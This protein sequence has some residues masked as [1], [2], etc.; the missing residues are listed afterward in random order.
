MA[1]AFRR[2][3]LLAAALNL[4][5]PLVPERL[6]VRRVWGA[7]LHAIESP[8]ARRP[9]RPMEVGETRTVS[10]VTEH[11]L[12]VARVWIHT[13][14]NTTAEVEITLSRTTEGEGVVVA[15]EHLRPAID[16]VWYE[17]RSALAPPGSY[18]IRVTVLAGTAAP[19]PAEGLAGDSIAWIA[20]T[21]ELVDLQVRTG[22]SGLA[23][24]A[25]TGAHVGIELPWRREGYSVTAADG[26]AFDT[27]IS[28][29]GRYV[30]AEEFKRMSAWPF[31]ID[32]I[33]VSFLS[34]DSGFTLSAPDGL[35]LTG[36][37]SNDTMTIV[38][39]TPTDGLE[40][41]TTASRAELTATLPRFEASDPAFAQR[42][43]RFFWERA[44]SWPFRDYTASA[45]GWRHWMTRVLS[46]T[47]TDGATGQAGDLAETPQDVQGWLWTRTDCPGWPF[48]DPNRY[49]TRHPS[50]SLSF[51]AGVVTHYSWT[52]DRDFLDAQLPRV[53]KALEHIISTYGVR[54]HGL[55][56]NTIADQDGQAGSL[57]SHYWDIVPGG[58][59]DAYAN[60]M[61]Y[62]AV[63]QSAR[64]ERHLGEDGRA[65]DLDAL[66]GTVKATFETEFWNDADGRFVQNID[67]TGAVHDYGASYLNLEALAVGLGTDEQARRIIDWLDHGTT[68]LTDRVLL[69]PP[70]GDSVPLGPGRALIQDFEAASQFRTVA[71]VITA[72]D[73]LVGFTLALED[74][75]GAQL[76][77]RHFDRWWDR[78]WAH[79]DAGTQPP[80]SYRL[81]VTADSRGLGWQQSRGSAANGSPVLSMAAVSDHHPGAPDIYSAWRFA[82]RA[83][84]RRNDFWYTFG[85]SGVETSY[86]DQV[87]DGGT[88]LYISGFDIEARARISA[89]L[90]FR[91]LTE[92]LD[93][94]DQPDRLC[95]GA[96]LYHGEIPQ[97]MLPGQVGVDNPFPESGL[98]PFAALPAFLGAVPTPEGLILRPHLP[99]ALGW[100]GVTN[101]H[102]RGERLRI[103]ANRESVTVATANT[104]LVC[105]VQGG[106][107]IL[108]QTTGE[109]HHMLHPFPTTK[110]FR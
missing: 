49:D 85:W 28:S 67:A 93:R 4:G 37:M 6:P 62:E 32:D 31:A 77:R 34:G 2:E 99:E 94:V 55:L 83:S 80:G 98:V 48:P 25:P 73:P 11:A 26:V 50:A 47:G 95:G 21:I 105:S 44:L 79:L 68:E 20:E 76:E 13:F 15:R 7:Q 107:A 56:V 42:L 18:E 58:H 12:S 75:E 60:A 106:Q 104:E 70:S 92:I 78:G 19:A 43:T 41:A 36:R 5:V 54:E 10:L 64:L 100:F 17:L 1:T 45:V 38:V 87:Q 8:P 108:L 109:G 63:I 71:V 82:P 65:A 53:R 16:Q 103:V 57:G 97:A 59:K 90:A 66:A 24:I 51:V 23:L 110:G 40:L 46:W 88:S 74:P 3:E 14:G 52:G 102:W 84:T 81:R 86:A 39:T 30:P 33:A 27:V 9:A 35:S 91:R 101:L 96:P 72:S 61:L 29:G 89:N 69:A 22:S